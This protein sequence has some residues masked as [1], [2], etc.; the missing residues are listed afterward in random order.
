MPVTPDDL[1]ALEERLLAKLQPSRAEEVDLPAAVYSRVMCF[2]G[3]VAR[4]RL[5]V[6]ADFVV[7]DG[8]RG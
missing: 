5:R 2:D 8:S 3:R 1:A 6:D 4:L 7:H